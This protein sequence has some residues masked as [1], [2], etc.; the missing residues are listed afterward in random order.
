VS[1]QYTIRGRTAAEIAASLEDAVRRGR[2]RAG[3]R[4]PPVRGLAGQL[5]VSP[6]TVAA[7]Y[8]ALRER[9]T[10]ASRVGS[11]TTIS[12]RPR[13]SLTPL[14]AVPEGIRD[15]ASGNPDR[16][17][18]PDLTKALRSIEAGHVLYG[19]PA[20]LPELEERARAR[21]A[22]SGI[23][24][25]NL[26]VV[27]GA[28]DGVE[29][30]L[31]AHLRPGDRV[32]V[33][34]PCYYAVLDLLGTMGLRPEPV[35]IDDRGPVPTDLSR[36]IRSGVQ[37][38]IVTPRAQNP[39]GAALDDV[40]AREIRRVLDRDRDV[41]VV[42]DDHAG[43]VAGAPLAPLA[44]GRRERWALVHSVA[45]SLG[46]DLRLAVLTGDP[47]T[48]DRVE[49]RR[50]IGPGWVSRILQE[51]VLALWADPGVGRF[52]RR[53]ERAYASRRRKLLEELSSRKIRAHGRSGLNVWI[54]VP[55]EARTVQMLLE[56]GWAVRGG[57]PFRLRTPPAVR[58]TVS[59]LSPTEADRF[60]SDLDRILRP[61]QR[62]RSA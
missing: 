27:S 29:R 15:L 36:A 41:L 54:P 10:L 53:A 12:S 19:E 55:D 21:F 4:L 49:G 35:K 30:V 17:L 39:A 1:T 6:G 59:T 43:P 56:R 34:D 20:N 7:A 40:R 28:L 5:R 42:E 8:R 38:V 50:L 14:A 57:E 37:A 13:P 62:G 31:E 23:P 61:P 51:T 33:E 22:A 32:A 48:I 25:A 16:S 24:A 2:L 9:G 46:P 26:S 52:L 58:V 18:L 45:K 47:T 3:D 60:A 11:G 44:D